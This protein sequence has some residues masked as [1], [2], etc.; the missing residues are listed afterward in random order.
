MSGNPAPSRRRTARAA[1]LVAIPVMLVALTACSEGPFGLPAASTEQAHHVG[2]LWLGAWIASLVI[3]GIVWALIGWA[4]IRYR[5]KDGDAPAPRQ[6]TYHLPLELLYTLVPFLIVGVLFFYTVKAQ[7]AMIEQTEE[8][9]VTINVI[10]QKW[11]WTFNYMEADNP[12]IGT[13]AHTVGT[14]EALPDLYLPVNKTVRFNLESADVIHSFWVPSF[15]FKRDVIPG[16][17]NSF[18]VTPNRIGTYDGKCAELCGEK[19]AAMLFKLHIVSEEEYA[20]KVKEIAANG[21]EGELELA[22]A[23]QAVLPTAAPEEHK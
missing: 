2:N 17:P 19:H 21:G 1:L 22:E 6:T 13:D 3:G 16:H 15:Y 11:S 5:R 9:E 8:P 12:A 7:D 10:G 23:M 20:E 18:D 4:V 14:V